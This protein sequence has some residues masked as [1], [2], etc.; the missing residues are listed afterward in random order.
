LEAIVSDFVGWDSQ[1]LERW[2]ERFAEGQIID[3][4]GRSTH[5]VEKGDGPPV[6]LVH[7]FNHDLNTWMANID[8]LAEHFKVY[9]L[10]LWGAGYSTRQELEYGFALFSEQIRLFMRQL[11]IERV[12]LVGH[13]MGGGTSI[14]LSVNHPELVD[15]V[16]LVGAV[17]VPRR[18]PLRGRLFMLPRIPELLMGLGTDA[19]RRK[20]LLDYWIHD[21]ETLTDEVYERM[22]RYQKIEG[23]TRA[24]LDIL[25]RNFFHTLDEEIHAL[26][27][28]DIPVLIVWGRHDRSVPLESGQT[29]HRNINASRLEVLDGAAHLVNFDQA[30]R[31]N[32]IVIDFLRGA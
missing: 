22:S 20:N 3:L 4:H 23:T 12:H 14:Y 15:R 29:M 5:F 7:G 24:S 26:S 31:F 21:P 2:A 25:R 16:V 19:I 6:I 8:A 28:L 17:G 10:D 30:E 1:P 13:S 32:R 9:A 18:L 11:G 27:G